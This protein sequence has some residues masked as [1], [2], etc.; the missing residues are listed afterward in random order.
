MAA[1]VGDALTAL[2]AVMDWADTF[3]VVGPIVGA[4]NQIKSL[5]DTAKKN[6]ANC[7]KVSN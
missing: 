6:K 4:L 5:S 1:V 2:Q 7:E 3:P